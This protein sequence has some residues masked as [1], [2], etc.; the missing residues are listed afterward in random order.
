MERDE[1]YDL[2]TPRPEQLIA[3]IPEAIKTLH[4]NLSEIL[5][6]L[7]PTQGAAGDLHMGFL[8]KA[9]ERR[10]NEAKAVSEL[11]SEIEGLAR[12]ALSTIK[13]VATDHSVSV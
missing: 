2:L 1:H 10:A 11:L 12:K 3:H 6:L 9:D 13:S 5:R 8:H 7:I 4:E